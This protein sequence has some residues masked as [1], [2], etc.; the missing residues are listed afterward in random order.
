MDGGALDNVP[1]DVVR[2]MGARFVIAVDVGN[3]PD[4]V[5]ELL[6][7]CR[8]GADRR[9]D[10]AGQYDAARCSPPIVIQV[11]VE[12]SAR[13]TGGAARTDGARL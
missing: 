9:L 6:D 8:D 1:A 11:D 13:S 4:K 7:V 5:V 12:G 10:D 2:D 3:A